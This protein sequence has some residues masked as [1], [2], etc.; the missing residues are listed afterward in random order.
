MLY[1]H[2]VIRGIDN[3]A[4]VFRKRAIELPARGGGRGGKWGMPRAVLAAVEGGAAD[5][6]A[7]FS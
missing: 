7:L 4:D 5:D 1:H 3:I 6:I 2:V